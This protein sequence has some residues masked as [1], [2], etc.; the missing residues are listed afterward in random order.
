MRPLGINRLTGDEKAL[1]DRLPKPPAIGTVRTTN[2]WIIEWLPEHAE[3][4][5][6]GLLLH[7]WMERTR[8]GWSVYKKCQTKRDVTTAIDR[9][10]IRAR[11]SGM[12]PILQLE[13]HGA[14]FGLAG[15]DGRGGQ[16]I[17]RWDELTDPLQ[18]LNFATCCNL[19]VFA[20]A[21]IG[22]AAVQVL[23]R[24][25]RAPAVAV[26]GPDDDIS[27]SKLLSG[28]KEFY[29]RW[30]DE[31]ARFD[32]VLQ[33][34]SR[35]AGTVNFE[36]EP[37]ASLAYDAMVEELVVSTRPNE[38]RLRAE[39]IQRLLP[40]ADPGSDVTLLRRALPDHWQQVWNEMFMIDLCPD[41]QSRFGLDMCALVDLVFTFRES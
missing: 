24:G 26:I 10:A 4:P 7:E 23:T 31:N 21:C 3:E 36:G 41:N 20:A 27:P 39:R 38:I 11:E 25:P 9:A 34:A 15:P 19:V 6:T 40:L 18:R 29:R 32:D 12:F 16:E 35:E 22:Y 2:V 1:V 33:S 30:Q 17:L 37:F 28:T 5:R 14:E 13:A 8:P